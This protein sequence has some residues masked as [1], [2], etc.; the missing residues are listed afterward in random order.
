MFKVGRKS[1]SPEAEKEFLMLF[2]KSA[3]Q[4]WKYF[5]NDVSLNF[6]SS[7]IQ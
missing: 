6:V 2:R 5:N 1:K 7:R 3:D 4:A